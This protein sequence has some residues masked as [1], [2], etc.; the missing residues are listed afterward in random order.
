METATGPVK[1]AEVI[2]EINPL[3][4][5]VRCENCG[6]GL[7]HR[8]SEGQ[9][10]KWCKR[11]IE[12]YY[13]REK[14]KPEQA[15]KIIHRLVEPRY[16]EAKLDDLDDVVG[17]K[18]IRK[19]LL[20]L[21]TGQ[22][23]FMFGSV[24]SGKTHTMAALIRQYVYEG[25]NCQRINFNDFCI[26]I[27]ST[28]SPA[29]KTTERDIVEKHREYDKLFIDDLGNSTVESQF[30]YDTLYSLINK[31]QERMLPTF[32]SSNMSIDQLGRSFDERIA[33]RLRTAA[34]IEMK[35]K[36]RRLG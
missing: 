3:L 11:C 14:L 20:G 6:Y 22:D 13:R 30:A 17:G 1:L 28:Y 4:E 7:R 32:V 9:Q 35:G 15:E 8:D 24:G 16:F 12:V 19:K 5:D 36:D 23:V 10:K 33:S 34:V 26:W 29:A 27:R 25:Y 31:R 2:A 18:E 21:E